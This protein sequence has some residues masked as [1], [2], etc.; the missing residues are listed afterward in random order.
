[1]RKNLPEGLPKISKFLAATALATILTAMVLA[2]DQARAA[3]SQAD[4]LRQADRITIG[5][6]FISAIEQGLPAGLL[7][8]RDS[9]LTQDPV[10]KLVHCCHAHPLPPYDAYCCHGGTTVY[11]APRYGYGAAGVRGV[12]RR[13]S[14]RTSRRVSRRR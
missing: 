7:G 3:T 5:A 1:M 13:T 10:L 2:P 12:S 11:V 4:T 14:R 9:V 6:P 8:T